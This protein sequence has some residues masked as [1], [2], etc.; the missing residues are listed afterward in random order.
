VSEVGIKRKMTIGQNIK[1]KTCTTG[2]EQIRE[3]KESE[4]IGSLK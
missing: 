1:G 2:E 4:I 3:N